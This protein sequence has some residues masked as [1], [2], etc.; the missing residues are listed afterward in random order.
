MPRLIPKRAGKCRTLTIIGLVGGIGCGKT[1]VAKQLEALGA[2]R[3]DAD[4]LAH[5]A[6]DLPRVR[7]AVVARF[8][9]AVL[10]PDGRIDRGALGR[11]AFA[12]REALRFLERKIH[13][14]V[15]A[16]IRSELAR[17][18]RTHAH[19]A[20]VLDVP[21][22]IES[23]LDALCTTTVFIETR[24]RDRA[25]RTVRDRGW[26]P[27]AVASR[28]RFQVPA[29]EKRRRADFRIDNRGTRAALTQN[30][31]RL[32]QRILQHDPCRG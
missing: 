12:D 14:V 25:G 21:L 22:L 27:N 13:P 16:E 9:R 3:I 15:R 31:K 10:G 29:T 11:K 19:A 23:G 1:S 7:R 17:E 5:A 4:A 6:L 2:L 24:R 8:G 26:A 18:R 30:V 32:F 20:V 28:E